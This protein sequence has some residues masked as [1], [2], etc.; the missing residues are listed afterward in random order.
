MMRR[1]SAQ[2]MPQASRCHFLSIPVSWGCSLWRSVPN[3]V[4]PAEDRSFLTTL[5]RQCAQALERSWLYAQERAAR[6]TAEEAVRLRDVFLTTAAHE[7]KT[8]L[9]SILGYAELLE[10]QLRKGNGAEREQRD[11][12]GRYD[13]GET[14]QQAD[15]GVT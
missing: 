7:L 13:S 15:C 14:T 2:E 5:G 10:R 11:G 9:T 12:A 8:P 3:G 4:L 6:S 1:P